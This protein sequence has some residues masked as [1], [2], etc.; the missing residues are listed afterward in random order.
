VKGPAR[1]LHLIHAGASRLFA[2]PQSGYVALRSLRLYPACPSLPAKSPITGF[3]PDRPGGLTGPGK[4]SWKVLPKPLA[5]LTFLAVEIHPRSRRIL[6]RGAIRGRQSAGN[7]DVPQASS[8]QYQV[9]SAGVTEQSEARWARR[10]EAP[11]SH[12]WRGL[13]LSTGGPLAA[14]RS[15]PGLWPGMAVA[16]RGLS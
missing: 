8:W 6:V 5:L 1:P 4:E 13:R 14:Y 10:A 15:S 2:A 11:P 3:V 7:R 12:T 9:A 16:W